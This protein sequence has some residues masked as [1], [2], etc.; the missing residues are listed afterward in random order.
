MQ[1]CHLKIVFILIYIRDELGDGSGFQSVQFREIENK[2]G[3]RDDEREKIG[4]QDYKD[5]FDLNEKA[6]LTKSEADE[7]TLRKVLEV[8]SL[9]K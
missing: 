5:K 8:C 6:H 3:L 1:S 9:V 7:K 2:L 4:G